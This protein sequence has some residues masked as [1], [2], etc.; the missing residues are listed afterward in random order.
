MQTE[1][2]SITIRIPVGLWKR[3]CL[4]RIDEK[5]KSIQEAAIEGFEKVLKE[6]GGAK[7]K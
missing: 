6:K 3:L 2:K 7:K 1:T 5:I 4:A